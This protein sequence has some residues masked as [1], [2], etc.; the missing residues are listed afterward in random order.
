VNGVKSQVTL[1]KTVKKGAPVQSVMS[2]AIET[3]NVQLLCKFPLFIWVDC[4]IVSSVI[5]GDFING[6]VLV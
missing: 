3:L 1:P 5:R 6:V 2:R 4:S